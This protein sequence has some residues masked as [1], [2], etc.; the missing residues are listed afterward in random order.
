MKIM[1]VKQHALKLINEAAT[2]GLSFVPLLISTISLVLI[3]SFSI[4]GSFD[5][6]E[7]FLIFISNKLLKC[8]SLNKIWTK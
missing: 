3:S 7:Y 1:A 4:I 8:L 5:I 2:R 6:F